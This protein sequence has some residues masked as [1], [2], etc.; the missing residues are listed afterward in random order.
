MHLKR[1]FL[2][3]EIVIIFLEQPKQKIFD[4]LKNITGKYL[5]WED[6]FFQ[7]VTG[8]RLSITVHKY[9]STSRMPVEV[10][11]KEYLT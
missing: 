9:V 5:H 1:T 7:P 4:E 10:T 2:E 11:E 6:L 3:A 8:T